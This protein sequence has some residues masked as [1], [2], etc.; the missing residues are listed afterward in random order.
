M[1]KSQRLTEI[2]NQLD[3]LY[4]EKFELEE[5]ARKENIEKWYKSGAPA[6]VAWELRAYRNDQFESSTIHLD[7]VTRIEVPSEY[8]TVFSGYHDSIIYDELHFGAD[9]SDAW[10]YGPAERVL[11]FIKEFDV[12]VRCSDIDEAIQK[13]VA[14]IDFYKNLYTRITGK[15]WESDGKS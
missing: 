15:D 5:E 9:D 14:K 2:Q 8:W 4:A 12:K 10:M 13:L 11:A 1:D 3:V 7:A 6:K